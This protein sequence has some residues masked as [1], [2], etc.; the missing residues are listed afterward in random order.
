MSEDLL[1]K[2]PIPLF[3][4]MVEFMKIGFALILHEIPAPE[5]LVL[6]VMDALLIIGLE[7]L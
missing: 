7:P 2:T 5:P 4:I 1:Q 3:P 6:F